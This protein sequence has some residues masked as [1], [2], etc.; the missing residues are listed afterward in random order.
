MGKAKALIVA[1]AAGHCVLANDVIYLHGQVRLQ[2]GTPPDHSVEIQMSCKGAD[3]PVRQTMT[4]K[5]GEFFL[6]VERDEFNH[7]ARALPAV[8]TGIRNEPLPGSCQI[9]AAQ[10]GYTSSGVDLSTFTINKDMKLPELILTRQAP[11]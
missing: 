9:I 3:H 10:S 5:K 11:R 6:K 1:I 7:V 8:S 2:G 4:N